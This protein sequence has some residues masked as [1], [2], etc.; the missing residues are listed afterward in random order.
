[1]GSGNAGDIGARHNDPVPKEE[2]TS[3][4]CRSCG[5]CCV[6]TQDDEAW[7]D[8]TE[9]DEKRLGKRFVRLHVIQPH[10]LN[11]FAAAIDG[12]RAPGAIATRWIDTTRG[13]FAGYQMNACTALDGDVGHHV[14]CTIYTKRPEVCRVA[15][16]PG[17]RSCRAIRDEMRRRVEDL[18]PVQAADLCDEDRETD[19]Y[20]FEYGEDGR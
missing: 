19:A 14:R 18:N 15:L 10:A 4:T 2:I 6:A 1:M 5:M 9:E 3:G 16:Q 13:P 11:S 8:L 20:R 12:R 7:A 17:D